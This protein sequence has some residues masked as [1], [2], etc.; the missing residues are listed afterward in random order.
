MS[1]LA[2][3]MPLDSVML[4][5][6]IFG[7]RSLLGKPKD[8]TAFLVWKLRPTF[9]KKRWESL[10]FLVKIWVFVSLIC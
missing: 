8:L 1:Y 5:G 7:F 4:Q 10:F 6:R 9:N 2:R 3:A